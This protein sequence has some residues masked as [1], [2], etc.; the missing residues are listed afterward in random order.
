MDLIAN[1]CQGPFASISRA[2]TMGEYGPGHPQPLSTSHSFSRL[3]STPPT[4]LGQSVASTLRNETTPGSIGPAMDA[5][6]RAGNSNTKSSDIF[7]KGSG[8]SST[9]ASTGATGSVSPKMIPEEFDE[10]PIEL[11][12]LTDRY[13]PLHCLR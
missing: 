9:A 6:Q 7:D 11:I 2:Q 3:E 4:P 8:R 10:L 5:F 1:Q 13:E 12:S